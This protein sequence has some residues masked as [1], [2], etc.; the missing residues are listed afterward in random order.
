MGFTPFPARSVGVKPSAETILQ[1]VLR[2]IFD[3][4]Q[5]SK[6]R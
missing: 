4:T 5:E 1:T 2:E 6:K 3:G